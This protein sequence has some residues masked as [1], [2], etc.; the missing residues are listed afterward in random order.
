[1]DGK[2][3]CWG[4]NVPTITELKATVTII[5]LEYTAFLGL[6]Q[7]VVR[8]T[9]RLCNVVQLDRYS[10]RILRAEMERPAES[11]EARRGNYRDQQCALEHRISYSLIKYKGSYHPSFILT[12]RGGIHSG[13]YP[14]LIHV[15]RLP[16]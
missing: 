14:V 1:M 6:H 11:T 10:A 9:S 8:M 13:G 3:E 16:A 5:D 2:R 4:K 7:R 15:I 12:A